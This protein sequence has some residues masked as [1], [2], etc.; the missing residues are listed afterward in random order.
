MGLMG[1]KKEEAER[2]MKLHY[3]CATYKQ[4]RE[5][6]EAARRS[7]PSFPAWFLH[8]LYL[9]V[10]KRDDSEREVCKTGDQIQARRR[11]GTSWIRAIF[12]KQKTGV[13]K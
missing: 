12:Y 9:C 6:I 13:T 2:A 10:S 11:R 8:R 7:H 5:W 3:K 1:R 4:Y